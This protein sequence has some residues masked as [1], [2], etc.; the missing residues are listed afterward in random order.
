MIDDGVPELHHPTKEEGAK[1]KQ[2]NWPLV[3]MR[4]AGPPLVA[5][6]VLALSTPSW[7]QWAAHA[8]FLVLLVPVAILTVDRVFGGRAVLA[9][10]AVIIALTGWLAVGPTPTTQVGRIS[11]SVAWVSDS[12]LTQHSWRLP[13]W[14]PAWKAAWERTGLAVVRVCL[15][16]P[17]TAQ[18]AGVRVMLNGAELPALVR[19]R[20]G[21]AG[22]TWFRTPV[23]RG[24]LETLPTT[25]VEFRPEAANLLAG[26]ML[27][28]YSHR[29]TAG[30]KA[31]RYF[32]GERWHDVDLAP[33]EAG[34]QSGRYIVELW[35]FD[36]Y[37]RVVMTWY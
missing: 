17:D 8:F 16:V 15:D 12:A 4:S 1:T 2:A 22:G 23:T 34:I 35:L 32:D 31:S 27:W 10:G 9:L 30:P 3:L 13:L 19:E 5:A 11:G 21:C 7:S 25:T 37:D 20:E 29:P 36:R 14:S 18:A 6:A 33:A 26:K 28:G 24:Q